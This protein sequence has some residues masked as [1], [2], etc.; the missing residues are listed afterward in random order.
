MIAISSPCN[1]RW[2]RAARWR[3]VHPRQAQQ[4]VGEGGGHAGLLAQLAHHGDQRVQL[5]RLAG[6]HVLQHRGLERAQLAR[7]GVAV[8]GL[9]VDGHADARADGPWPPASP[10]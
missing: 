8:F 1:E 6:F 4:R 9:L 5:H 10:R 2:L 7:D 3:S